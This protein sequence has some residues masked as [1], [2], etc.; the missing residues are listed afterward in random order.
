MLTHNRVIL[1]LILTELLAKV[2]HHQRNGFSKLLSHGF[3]V[4]ALHVLAHVPDLVKNNSDLFQVFL[5]EVTNN[6]MRLHTLVKHLLGRG[7]VSQTLVHGW[8]FLLLLKLV[9]E[10]S[11]VNLIYGL[12]L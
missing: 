3:I 8:L 1:I 4:I 7:T 2:L 12:D 9:L 6:R 5:I 10:R 11:G